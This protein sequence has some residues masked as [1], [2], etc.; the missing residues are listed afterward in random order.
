MAAKKKSPKNA[1]RAVNPA[2]RQVDQLRKSVKVLK[3]KLERETRARKAE[4]RIRSE[5]KKAGAQLTTQ[6]K[7]LR[8]QG[9]K[10][11][12]ELKSAL[13]D[14]NRR[15]AARK[16]ALA[17]VAELK[18]QYAKTSSGLRAELAQK[19]AELKR[20][21]EELMRLAGQ[22]AHRAAEIIR[23]EEHHA[24]AEEP[25]AGPTASSYTE[26]ERSF[27]ERSD[28]SRM[29][30]EDHGDDEGPDEEHR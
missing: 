21:S 2:L 3:A 18:A 6:L 9:K 23:G 13:G 15:E 22:S 19:S 29:E 24:P 5:T 16:E 28:E 4:E 20:K 14:S 30:G 1:R 12:A 7:A 17:K 27:P 26:S 25:P 10:L 11:A 8:D